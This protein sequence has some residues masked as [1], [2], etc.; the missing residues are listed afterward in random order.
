MGQIV[1]GEFRLGDKVCFK[2]DCGKLRQGEIVL[3]GLNGYV[4][5]FDG[6][7]AIKME[8]ELEY[9]KSNGIKV[10]AEAKE[11]KFRKGDKV[12]YVGD[13]QEYK[14]N[15][16]VIDGD[17]FFNDYYNQWQARSIKSDTSAVW[18]ICNVPLSD[19]EPY[20]EPIVPE[21]KVGDKVRGISNRVAGAVG[22]VVTIY[23]DGCLEVLCDEGIAQAF[24]QCW[25]LVQTKEQTDADADD[26]AKHCDI[27]KIEDSTDNLV[28]ELEKLIEVYRKVFADIADS[29]D[30][31]RYEADLAK[32]VALKVA[33]KHED[34]K[35]AA[36]YAVSVAKA[37]VEGLKKK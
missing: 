6:C 18:G 32:E 23:D 11:A 8:S 4:V 21:F 20:A 31:P 27:P 25:E 16:Y 30:W 29:F 3:I 1:I 34:P 19:L 10:D 35:K 13:I 33:N 12:R 9:S 14:G 24:P 26:T 36:E 5:A 22:V 37:V 2:D 7:V 15:V 17:I 28:G